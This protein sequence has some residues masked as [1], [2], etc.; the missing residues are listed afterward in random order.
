[1]THSRLLSTVC[2]AALALGFVS[3]ATRGHV[4]APVDLAGNWVLNV[5][6]SDTADLGDRAN[7][8]GA[9]RQMRFGIRPR[10]GPGPGQMRSLDDALAELRDVVLAL[11]RGSARVNITHSVAATTLT[12]ADSTSLYLRNSGART[13]ILWRGVHEVEARGKW[14]GPAFVSE[15]RLEI[16]LVVRET[17]TRPANSM[18]LVV[19]TVIEGSPLREVKFKRVYDPAT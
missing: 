5:S 7:Q 19:H 6:Q 1:M 15:R 8:S 3:C 13:R 11:N 16:G 2:S 18:Q 14:R 12:F 17:F 4:G 10:I 9:A